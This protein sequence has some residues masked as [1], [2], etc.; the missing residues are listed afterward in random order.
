MVC[1]LRGLSMIA[2]LAM[3][4][5]P[6]ASAQDDLVANPFHKFWAGSKVGSTAVHL[7]Q[8]KLSGPDGKLVPDGLDEK[9]IAYKLV[10]SDNDKVIIE[11][12]VTEREFLGFVQS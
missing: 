8:T 4:F 1:H 9:R 10:E 3:L 7:E 5:S 6:M 12:V 11:M 2:C